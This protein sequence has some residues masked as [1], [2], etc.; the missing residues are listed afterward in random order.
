MGYNPLMEEAMEAIGECW[1]HDIDTYRH[2]ITQWVYA[3][4]GGWLR[5]TPNAKWQTWRDCGSLIHEKI[6]K[7]NR[8]FDLFL[9]DGGYTK[10]ADLELESWYFVD[11]VTADYAHLWTCCCLFLLRKLRWFEICVTQARRPRVEEVDLKLPPKPQSQIV[12]EA[13]AKKV[14]KKKDVDMVRHLL[15]C[16]EPCWTSMFILFGRYHVQ[17]HLRRISK[18]VSAQLKTS[19]SYEAKLEVQPV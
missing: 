19:G 5:Q 2:G 4:I 15:F 16:H 11:V 13:A 14:E 9:D 3:S 1:K 10:V 8:I 12:A 18:R 17:L 7:N 6:W